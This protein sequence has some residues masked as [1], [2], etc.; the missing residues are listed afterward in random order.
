M[1]SSASMPPDHGPPISFQSTGSSA[2]HDTCKSP[3]RNLQGLRH[4]RHRRPH[5]DPGNRRAIG[6]AIGSE[7]LARGGKKIVIGHDGR[8]SG[9]ALAAALARGIQASGVGVIDDRAGRDA[10]GLLRGASPPDRS[11]VAVTGSHNPPDYNGLKIDAG[12]RDAC[13]RGDPG[14]AQRIEKRRSRARHRQLSSGRT[15]PRLPRAHRRRREARAADEA[16]RGLRQRRAGRVRARALP[17]ASAARSPSS[18]ARWTATSPTITP[19]RRS[20]RT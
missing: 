17:R 7:A 15:S 3:A 18:T 12:R 4:P 8:L 9:P 5:A 10:D 19:I 13:G 20:P 16:R 11:G 2:I 1:H 6:R 14:A